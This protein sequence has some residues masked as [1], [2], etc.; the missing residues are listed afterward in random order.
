L[1]EQPAPADLVQT[2]MPAQPKPE[3]AAEKA[4]AVGS[5]GD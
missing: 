5:F 1:K 4:E 2:I 3:P